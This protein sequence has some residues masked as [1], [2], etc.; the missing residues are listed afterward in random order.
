MDNIIL[1]ELE[2]QE[3]NG[4][5]PSSRKHYL[6]RY[7][8]CITWFFGLI[9]NILS[10]FSYSEGI[11]LSNIFI[12]IALQFAIPIFSIYYN[13][14]HA[15]MEQKQKQNISK[16]P[17]WMIATMIGI[18]LLELLRVIAQILNDV[19]YSVLTISTSFLILNL[20][21]LAIVC[22]QE[23]RYFKWD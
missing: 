3:P 9:Y 1:D 17:R 22:Y 5:I 2:D 14:I 7:F 23:V 16:F 8:L 11:D 12:L 4:G 6:S 18:L 21:C 19:T 10:Y 15:Y 13:L 20:F